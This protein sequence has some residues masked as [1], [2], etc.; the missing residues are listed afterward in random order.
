[1]GS[2]R[3]V[4]IDSVG[5]RRIDAACFEGA[6]VCG[7]DFKVFAAVPRCGMDEAR[8]GVVGDMVPCE[9][10]YVEAVILAFERMRADDPRE[11][12]SRNLLHLFVA[13]DA[14]L[15]EHIGCEL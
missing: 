11:H 14:G 8:S 7:P 4:L 12:R 3:A 10:W 6:R 1:M 5:D 13:S 15:L 9:Q 2:E